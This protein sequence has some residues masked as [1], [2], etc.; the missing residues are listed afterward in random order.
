VPTNTLPWDGE[1]EEGDPTFIV[2]WKKWNGLVEARR[3]PVS[4][5]VADELRT[6][7]TEGLRRLREL[8]PVEYSA[9]AEVDLGEEYLL[10]PAD[11]LSRLA[12]TADMSDVGV[13]NVAAL[14][15]ELPV[16]SAGDL[17]AQSLSFYGIGLLVGGEWTLF[18]RKAN[19]RSVLNRGARFLKYE[20]TLKNMDRPDLT[21]DDEIDFVIRAGSAFVFRPSGFRMLTSDVKFAT[22]RVEA[23]VDDIVARVTT[24]GFSAGAVNALK[25][26]GRRKSSVA[27]RLRRVADQASSLN[28]TVDTV[29]AALTTHGI[30][31]DILVS[32]GEFSFDEDAVSVFMDL[33]EGRL[34]EQD[35]TGERVRADRF[36]RR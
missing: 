35:F 1:H 19:P 9:Y 6:I 30:D 12:A 8:D 7:S 3:I 27:G 13:V 28:L 31:P 23:H 20:D 34:Y 24:A 32:G 14:V 11:Q 36:R 22:D 15:D 10:L 5:L 2:G 26:V 29:S 18:V 17:A 16:M 4:T 33:V 25:S 21:I